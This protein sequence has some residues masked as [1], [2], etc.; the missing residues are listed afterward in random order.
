MKN[1]KSVLV[2]LLIAGLLS[3]M[4]HVAP[5]RAVEDT[6]TATGLIHEYWAGTSYGDEVTG[7][8][9]FDPVDGAPHP[10]NTDP[11]NEWFIPE[12]NREDPAPYGSR[13]QV[14][15]TEL[16]HEWWNPEN[17]SWIIY[18]S[19]SGAPHP[20]NNATSC[21]EYAREWAHPYWASTRTRARHPPETTPVE[22][23]DS[24]PFGTL[25]TDNL[26]IVDTWWTSIYNWFVHLIGRDDL[27][28]QGG[29]A[30]DTYNDYI[31]P[32]KQP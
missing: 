22:S 13:R 18:D 30:S 5:A 17:N 24:D 14:R 10:Y 16:I 20:E 23:D 29:S 32:D 31:D 1:V 7:W 4:Y 26:G 12:A 28:G 21:P 15:N 25:I 8:V 11:Q 27:H 3:S 2:C 6:P 9:Q 19:V